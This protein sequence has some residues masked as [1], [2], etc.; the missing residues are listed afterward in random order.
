[1]HHTNHTNDFAT[2]PALFA[3][4]RAACDATGSVAF[5]EESNVY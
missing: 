2:G 5:V 4:L 3:L 1:M